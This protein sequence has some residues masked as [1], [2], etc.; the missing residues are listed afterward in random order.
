MEAQ[1][2]K[3]HLYCIS[4]LFSLPAAFFSVVPTP[5]QLPPPPPKGISRMSHRDPIWP[6]STMSQM[7]HF[8]HF[9]DTPSDTIPCHT[10]RV[11][12]QLAQCHRCHTSQLEKR[13]FSYNRCDIVTSLPRITP[14]PTH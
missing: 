13:D 4:P 1:T 2:T 10:V 6:A 7:S 9:C 12:G 5:S 3:A 14:I 8:S 11:S